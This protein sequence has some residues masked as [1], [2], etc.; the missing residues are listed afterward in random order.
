VEPL[1]TALQMPRDPRL[2]GGAE[3]YVNVAF[4]RSAWVANCA[5]RQQSVQTLTCSA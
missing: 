3:I 2:L 4:G 1:T 5:D